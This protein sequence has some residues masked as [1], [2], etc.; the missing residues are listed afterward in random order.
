MDPAVTILPKEIPPDATSF[1]ANGKTYR[2]ASGLSFQRYRWME[3]LQQEFWFGRSPEE[4]FK[5]EKRAYE[6]IN[7]LSF[8]DAAVCLDNSMRGV[9]QVSDRKINA[10]FRLCM[11][12]WNYDGED[13]RFMT[14][15]LMA[16]KIADMEAEGIEAGF[17]FVQAARSVPGY[18]A[19]CTERSQLSS[20]KDPLENGSGTPSANGTASPSPQPNASST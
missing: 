18:I 8:A 15:E 9:G 11:L 7:K 16:S 4:T 10:A 2:K 1:E 17:F 20:E 12:F 14:D 5:S 6:L 3:G 13:A 19:A